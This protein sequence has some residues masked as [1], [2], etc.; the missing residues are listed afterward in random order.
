MIP[1]MPDNRI[2]LFL[3]MLSDFISEL[4]LKV[5]EDGTIS[6]VDTGQKKFSEL[7]LPEQNIFQILPTKVSRNL[8][9]TMAKVKQ[10]GNFRTL[11][12]GNTT[13]EL[14]RLFE[15]RVFPQE[16]V[17][18]SSG[19]ERMFAI[20]IQKVGNTFNSSIR[21]TVNH[22]LDRTASVFVT[23]VK[24]EIIF[25][26]QKFCEISGY[27]EQE[28][29]GQKYQFFLHQSKRDEMLSE[30]IRHTVRQSKTW[31]GEIKYTHKKGRDYWLFSS[32]IPHLNQNGKPFRF[33]SVG[34]DITQTKLTEELLV[35]SE[36]RFADIY[37]KMPVMLITTDGKLRIQDVSEFCVKKL[38]YTK[39]ELIGKSFLRFVDMRDIVGDRGKAYFKKLEDFDGRS[40]TMK[41][42][43][44]GYSSFM[45]SYVTSHFERDE[46]DGIKNIFISI[47]DIS[48][49]RRIQRKLQD[50]K[51]ALD[52]SAIVTMTDVK[53][54]I[55]YGN[56]KF[57]EVSGY[58]PDEFL[59]QSHEIIKSG[60]HPKEFIQDMWNTIANGK[61]WR[62]EF[63]NKTKLGRYYWVNTTIVPIMNERGKPKKYL[64]IRFDI[65]AKKRLE[66][67]IVRYNS[68]LESTVSK[69]TK[70]LTATNIELRTKNKYILDSIQYAKRIQET[71]LPPME[72]IQKS[73]KQFFILWKPKDSVSGDFYWFEKTTN[74]L[75]IAA[76]D[77]TGH[78]VPGAFMS[79]ISSTLLKEIMKE[80]DE[81][82][83]NEILN[84]LHLRIR[85]LLRQHENNSRDGMDIAL[86]R[87]Q[88]ETRILDFAGA[89]NPLIL[90]QNN[91]LQRIRG[92]R[93]G[94]A[95]RHL[96]EDHTFDNQ[97]IELAEEEANFYLFT[98]GYADQFGGIHKQKL[99]STQFRQL[100][101]AIHHESPDQ[102]E[103]LLDEHFE[104]WR[105]KGREKQID[106]VLVIGVKV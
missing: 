44:K 22:A 96:V 67:E 15:I 95:G 98:D 29:I 59:G 74:Y 7:N 66:E 69:R 24:S 55:L 47:K 100:L 76:A 104:K 14:I 25:V 62:G 57:V 21:E 46:N 50:Q 81:P 12:F 10:E 45:E 99:R 42:K 1:H 58:T 72:E 35:R 5:T 83:P 92:N 30:E 49:L 3:V 37:A 101:Q 94:I 17:A 52:E 105:A 82:A 77:C 61:V 85:N 68:E 33:V 23:N 4:C 60:Y 75:Y 28:L 78:G 106:D 13:D 63:R 56:E 71:L 2:D 40:I 80:K 31:R 19:K 90:I 8:K 97:S 84:E 38:G 73:F 65:T 70:E 91:E 79:M 93:Y 39:E 54:T 9:R 86:C 20:F 64:A 11:D 26:N 6:S 89:H 27:S 88:P 43:R 41:I 36:K 87:Y 34:F 48:K 102:Q 18:S 16:S 32:I 53:G 103:Y 51:Y